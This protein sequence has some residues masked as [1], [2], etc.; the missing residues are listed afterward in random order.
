MVLPKEIFLLTK[1]NWYHVTEL[2][3][4]PLLDK[5]FMLL[6]QFPP[7]KLLPLRHFS[8]LLSW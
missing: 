7:N 8:I 1:L 5:A 2:E 6:F 3:R 4:V